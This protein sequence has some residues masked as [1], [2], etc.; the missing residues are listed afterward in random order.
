MTGSLNRYLA[1][2]LGAF[3]LIGVGSMAILSSGGSIAA[4]AFGFGLALLI[5]LYMFGSVSGGHYN[6][7][8]TLAQLIRG[9]I[10]AADAV[11]YIVAQLAGAV[12]ASGLVAAVLGASAVGRTVVGDG[13]G[14]GSIWVLALEALF[15]AFLVIVILRVTSGENAAAPVVIGLTLVVIHLALVPITGASVNPVRS[16]GPAIVA[17]DFTDAWAYIVGPL[18]GGAVAVYVDRFINAEAS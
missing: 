8:V 18:V 3:V 9:Q 7:A 5:A 11:G 6:P 14:I 12:L 15:T 17:A 2:L 16:L 10:T 1:E 4:I 13:A